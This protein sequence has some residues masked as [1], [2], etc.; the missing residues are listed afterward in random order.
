MAKHFARNRGGWPLTVKTIFDAKAHREW[1]RATDKLLS[2]K[3]HLRNTT[4]EWWDA[5][6]QQGDRDSCDA[7]DIIDAAMGRVHDAERAANDAAKA[8]R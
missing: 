3:D 5:V 7:M 8:G 1:V 2:A 6:I 4:V